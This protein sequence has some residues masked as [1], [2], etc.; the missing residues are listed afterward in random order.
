MT[1]N[2]QFVIKS[3]I[4]FPPLI[5]DLSHFSKPVSGYFSEFNLLFMA[6]GTKLYFWDY[7]SNNQWFSYDGIDQT[8][9]FVDLVRLKQ[10][11]FDISIEY[12]I[13]IVTT[14]DILLLSIQKQDEH[15]LILLQC[16]FQV[17]ISP[18]HINV[19]LHGQTIT[20]L[21]CTNYGRVLLGCTNGSIQE[22]I[23]EPRV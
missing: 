15:V 1:L 17:V 20:S 2:T 16:H 4:P 12:G 18:L 23:Y 14:S 5:Q 7:A 9:L 11:I 8:I 6:S 21:I 13:V 10:G 22:F 3:R 19:P